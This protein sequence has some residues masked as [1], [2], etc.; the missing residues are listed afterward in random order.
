MLQYLIDVDLRGPDIDQ[1]PLVR[2]LAV[3]YAL[4]PLR[5]HFG[6]TNRVLQFVLTGSDDERAHDFA[7][8]IIGLMQHPET[9]IEIVEREV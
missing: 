6:E 8:E 3:G 7:R 5:T 2:S 9:H 1:T 4:L